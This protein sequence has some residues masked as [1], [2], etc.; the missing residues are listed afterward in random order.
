MLSLDLMPGQERTFLEKEPLAPAVIIKLCNLGTV[1]GKG[2]PC[3][4]QMH[5]ALRQYVHSFDNSTINVPPGACK[6]VGGTVVSI[7]VELS[8]FLLLAPGCMISSVI[9]V[10]SS[11][12]SPLWN[13][14]GRVSC[15]RVPS[16]CSF[17]HHFRTLLLLF[18]T[19]P[20]HGSRSVACALELGNLWKQ[21][22]P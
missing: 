2:S 15:S 11:G 16:S 21:P 20:S 3:V 22:V 10:L 12:G 17:A 1:C 4:W 13:S 18:R 7:P 6:H 5:V 9:F 8:Y 14:K 19:M